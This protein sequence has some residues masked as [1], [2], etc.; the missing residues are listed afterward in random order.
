MK[1]P[2]IGSLSWARTTMALSRV[3]KRL[4]HYAFLVPGSGAAA[5]HVTAAD[6]HVD[7]ARAEQLE[8]ARQQPLVVLHV[9]VHDGDHRRGAGQH[10]H[11]AG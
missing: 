9:G 1:K 6:H 8:H 5:F 11:D 2:L 4:I 7:V 10:A 3:A